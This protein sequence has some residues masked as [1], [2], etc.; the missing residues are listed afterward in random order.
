MLDSFLPADGSAP[1]PETFIIPWLRASYWQ[2]S[3]EKAMRELKRATAVVNS[4]LK[5]VGTGSGI[6]THCA[7]YSS[8]QTLADQHASGDRALYARARYPRR[9]P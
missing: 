6:S 8:R 5:R 7:R 1:N 3:H 2:M 9:A 4:N